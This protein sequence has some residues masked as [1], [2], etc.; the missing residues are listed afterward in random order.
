[1][2]RGKRLFPALGEQW[3]TSRVRTGMPFFEYS[4]GKKKMT[5]G[6]VVN[7]G[8]RHA[9]LQEDLIPRGCWVK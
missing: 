3:D 1:M 8:R 2:A 5:L 9:E 6:W 4:L 7:G